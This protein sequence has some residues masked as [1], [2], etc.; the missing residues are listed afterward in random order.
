LCLA[1]RLADLRPRLEVWVS[2]VGRPAAALPAPEPPELMTA[3]PEPAVLSR[4]GTDPEQEE[5]LER[6]GF[7]PEV[8]TAPP[9]GRASPQ[10]ARVENCDSG[11]P[12]AGW[13]RIAD[14]PQFKGFPA[15]GQS[16]VSSLVVQRWAAR[17][18]S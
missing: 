5:N 10:K 8:N 3:G 14:C 1:E 4:A 18:R 9:L 13:M 12:P 2:A 17:A 11:K 7:G 16:L 6:L 15:G